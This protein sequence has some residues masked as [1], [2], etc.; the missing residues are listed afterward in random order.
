MAL[1]CRYV[2]EVIIGAPY[3]LT[4]DLINTLNIHKVVNV[5]SSDD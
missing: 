4:N 1:A 3:I 2:D 5:P